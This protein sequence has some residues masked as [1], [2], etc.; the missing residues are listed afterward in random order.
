MKSP[1]TFAV[2]T[3]NQRAVLMQS[4][5]LVYLLLTRLLNLG[6]WWHLWRPFSVPSWCSHLGFHAVE[7]VLN[8]SSSEQ[9]IS[10]TSSYWC[11]AA[12]EKAVVRQRASQQRGQAGKSFSSTVTQNWK[13]RFKSRFIFTFPTRSDQW[14]KERKKRLPSHWNKYSVLLPFLLSVLNMHFTEGSSRSCS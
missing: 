12:R 11:L 10:T 3:S 7:E 5:L 2:A 14:C 6:P 13:S 9:G 1:S 8:H 4:K